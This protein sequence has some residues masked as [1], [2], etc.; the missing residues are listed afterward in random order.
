MILLAAQHT[1]GLDY[2]ALGLLL[3]LATGLGARGS[4]KGRGRR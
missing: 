2:G 4:T 3:M 1:S